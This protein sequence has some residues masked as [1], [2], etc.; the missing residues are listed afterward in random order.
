M[1]NIKT[2]TYCFGPEAFRAWARDIEN[3]KFDRMT[4]EDFDTWCDHTN[5]VCVLATNGSCCHGFLQKA[6]ELNPDMSFLEEVSNLYKKMKYMANGD[7]DSLE[8]LD[9]GFNVSLETLQDKEKRDKIASK[10]REFADV[11]DEIVR[12]I[13]V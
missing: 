2:E 4:T 9:G 11:T 3:G 6:R 1:Q 5:Y 13:K 10:I 8:A 12:I 7:P